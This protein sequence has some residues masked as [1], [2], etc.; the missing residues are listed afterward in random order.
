M[1]WFFDFGANFSD[2]CLITLFKGR[3]IP[4][5]RPRFA[6]K[7][8]RHSRNFA[9]LNSDYNFSRLNRLLIITFP[10]S[11]RSYSQYEYFFPLPGIDLG[12]FSI[13][14]VRALYWAMTPFCYKKIKRFNMQRK[15]S[16]RF[17][18]YRLG[19]ISTLVHYVNHGKVWTRVK[20]EPW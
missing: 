10:R 9:Q 3:Y 5:L 16:E 7:S 1:L 19:R 6:G 11:S 12:Y 8:D 15:E 20:C 13:Q 4:S 2:W 18:T 17:F 14:D